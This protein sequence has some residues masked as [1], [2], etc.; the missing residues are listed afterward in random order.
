MV[1]R[2]SLFFVWGP[3]WFYSWPIKIIRGEDEHGW[4]TLGV[5]T[6]AGSI[7]VRT[8][9]CG[10]VFDPPPISGRRASA[11]IIDDVYDG[12][13][14]TREELDELHAWWKATGVNAESVD[15]PT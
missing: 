10:C 5:V 8:N 6:W 15:E 3:Q 13:P 12:L 14:P 9:Y 11:I 4:R 7:F 2:P 1:K